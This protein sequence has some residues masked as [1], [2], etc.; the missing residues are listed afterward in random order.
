[1]IPDGFVVVEVFGQRV[2]LMAAPTWI[3]ERDVRHCL[4]EFLSNFGFVERQPDTEVDQ[5]LRVG[6]LHR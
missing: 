5:R 1:M 6:D 4:C 2:D 3:A